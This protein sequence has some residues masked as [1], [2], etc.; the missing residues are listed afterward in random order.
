MTVFTFGINHR[1]ASL[2]I[3]DKVAFAPD[4]IQQ[5]L[6]SLVDDLSLQEAAILSTCNRTEIYGFGDA[7]RLLRWLAQ[8]RRISE[9]QI[10]GCCYLLQQEES[11]KHMMKVA[12]GL[13][14]M[15]LGEP[16][17]LGQLKSAYAV[18][19]ETGTL[20]GHLHQVFQQAF[21]I[22]KRVRTET[23][24]GENPVSVAY[25]AVSLSQ[26]IFADLREVTALLIGAGETV[27]LVAKHLKDKSVGNI[28][29]A[30]RTLNRAQEVAQRYGGEAIL[31]SEIPE[32]LYQADMVVSST[33]SQL[34]ILGKGAVESALKVRKHK[35][36]FML[37]IAVPRDIEPE[38][39]NLNDVYLYTVDDLKQVID[40]NLRGREEAADQA[41][42]IVEQGV[43][44][45]LRQSRALE[46]VDTIRAYRSSAEE[47]RD[48]E[49]EKSLRQLQAGQN[50]EEIMRQLANSLTKKLLHTPTT[51]L[52]QAA[53]EGVTQ[54]IEWAHRLFGLDKDK[55]SNDDAQE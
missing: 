50:P 53:E 23:A 5:C 40:E 47:I 15:V 27:D 22:A 43:D 11:V 4:E 48:Q 42:L 26:Q 1:S 30:N 29:V 16:Q 44:S 12:S 41:Q 32:N 35:P 37:D 13:D 46:A 36:V 8:S 54:H 7:S 9:S 19:R 20:Q 3:R 18:A 17:I 28:I 52:R 25:A 49:V 45:W 6:L 10:E 31:L 24:I 39:G 21:A 14:S 38:V 51:N 55:S 34:P 33:A 2:D